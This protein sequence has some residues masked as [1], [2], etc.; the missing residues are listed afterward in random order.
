[1]LRPRTLGS[2]NWEWGRV[3]EW[4]PATDDRRNNNGQCLCLHLRLRLPG[5]LLWRDQLCGRQLQKVR[6]SLRGTEGR[7][8]GRRAFQEENALLRNIWPST[9]W[10][11]GL[12]TIAFVDIKTKV[13]SQ[14][15]LL[16]LK[17]K[18]SNQPN[19]SPCRCLARPLFRTSSSRGITH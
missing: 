17:C 9:G 2:V 6:Q 7:Q 4:V 12:I 13:L 18:A 5:S 8:A 10:P 14:N 1:M 11:V 3:S 19:G 15:R 16:I